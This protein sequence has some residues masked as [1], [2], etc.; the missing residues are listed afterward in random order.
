MAHSVKVASA[1][2]LQEVQR[3]AVRQGYEP[4]VCTYFETLYSP[5]T[6]VDGRHGQIAGWV[7]LLEA[8]A[9]YGRPPIRLRATVKALSG[10][11][12]IEIRAEAQ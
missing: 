7:M 9:P 6:L 3:A 5:R 8:A 10:S 2:I 4:L 1:Q 12:H 11:R